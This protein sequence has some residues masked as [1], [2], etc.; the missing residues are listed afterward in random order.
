MENLLKKAHDYLDSRGCKSI[1]QQYTA[2]EVA[3]MLADFTEQQLINT[4]ELLISYEMGSNYGKK[5]TTLRALA[6]IKVDKFL[7][8]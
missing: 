3:E 1:G 4:R 8:K 6:E 7:N 2:L 5:L